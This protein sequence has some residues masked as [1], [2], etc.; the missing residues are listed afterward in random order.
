MAERVSGKLEEEANAILKNELTD[1][2]GWINEQ[3]EKVSEE[4][5]KIEDAYK[6]NAD[7]LGA[8]GAFSEEEIR[9]QL[10][11]VQARIDEKK[12]TY[13]SFGEL[14]TRAKQVYE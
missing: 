4:A 8:T 12:A 10:A 11:P 13:E 3:Q 5:A 14:L 9:K 7:S 6:S 2:E 1:I